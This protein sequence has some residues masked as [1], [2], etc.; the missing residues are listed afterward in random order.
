MRRWQRE[1]AKAGLDPSAGWTRETEIRVNGRV[2]V[3][4]TEISFRGERGRF[5][6]VERVT[7]SAGVSW[8][9]VIG[10]PKGIRTWRAFREERVRTVHTKRQTMTAAEAKALARDKAAQ[11]RAAA[12]KRERL[13]KKSSS[14]RP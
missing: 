12:E 5:R 6:F 9:S 2:V 4:G 8:L 14:R 10:G 3:P 11:R 7:T 1:R 13:A